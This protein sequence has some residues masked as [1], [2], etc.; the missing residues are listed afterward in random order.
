MSERL[1]VNRSNRPGA[2]ERLPAA[3]AAAGTATAT[4][5]GAGAGAAATLVRARVIAAH[6]QLLRLRTES[7]EEV[8][9]R[10]PSREY[11]VVC[12]DYVQ[13]EFDARH[14]A[15]RIVALEPRSG[16]LYRSNARG[17]A[18]LIAANL[19]L[20]LVVVAPLPAPDFYMVDRYLAAAQC[21]GIRAAVVLNKAELADAAAID[22]A[23]APELDAY[24]RLGLDTLRVSALAATGL[25]E[26][27]TLLRDQTAVLVGQSGV[28]KS[29][30]LRA[31]VPGSTASVG[32]LI[33]DDEGRHTTT[34]TWLYPLPGGG[35]L[36]DSPGVR[37]F[38]PAI[39]RLEPAALGFS[40]IA[41]LSGQ[42]R[43]ADCAHLREPDCAVQQA[44]GGPLSPRRYE[45]Y[46]RLRR[47]YERLHGAHN[48]A[49]T[50][51]RR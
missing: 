21:A 42:C 2:S 27:H 38:A 29:S 16:A 18:E 34:A 5:A 37:D 13:C 31:L 50:R 4:A 25:A 9:A 3:P 32:A 51:R 30:L 24:A 36:I 14:E 20:L 47:L 39:D 8:L 48:P 10:T 11:S 22:A 26:L 43:F 28:G 7:G 23:I 40:E 15:L 44:V 49:P 19:S 46:R 41:A 35:A 17:Q 6:G 45:S 33:R 12:G 1:P